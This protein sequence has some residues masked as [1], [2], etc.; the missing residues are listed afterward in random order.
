MIKS[1]KEKNNFRCI[2]CQL[3]LNINDNPY[4]MCYKCSQ[5]SYVDDVTPIESK[6][7]LLFQEKVTLL[8]LIVFL[9]YILI[10]FVVS[11]PEIPFYLDRLM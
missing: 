2:N 7:F 8:L 6:D 1:V 4:M 9:V 10:L 3:Q 11:P 5:Q